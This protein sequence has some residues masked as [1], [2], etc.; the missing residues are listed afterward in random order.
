MKKFIYIFLTLCAAVSCITPFDLDYDET[1]VI[2][3]EAY[4]GADSEY[5]RL[6][7]EPAYSKSNSVTVIPFNPVIVFEVD[8][9]PVQV[10]CV[11]A[12]DGY[13][14][15]HHKP[16]PGEKMKVSVTS[17]G[18]VGISAET[19]IPDAF[20]ARKIDYR[21]VETGIDKYASVLYI[22]PECI[23]PKWC[24]GV[25]FLNEYTYEDI[26]GP[27]TRTYKYSGRLF[28]DPDSGFDELVP[29][30]MTAMNLDLLGA[31]LW[32][33][34]GDQLDR[35][36]CTFALQ[37]VSTWTSEYDAHE[38]FYASSGERMQYDEEGNVIGVGKYTDRNKVLLYT[39]TDEFYKYR[40]AYELQMDYDGIVG[41]IAPANFC[42]SNINNGYGAFAGIYIVETDWITKDFIENN[43]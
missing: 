11:D 40:V 26:S 5:I 6:T 42:Y 28:P 10:E 18:F 31:T 19:V 22:T 16:M 38:S 1:P 29:M 37:P 39:M 21:L 2:F 8:G 41:V 36:S 4:P 35:N 33:W 7:I 17:E 9:N 14:I 30:S 3:L 43:R 23:D 27:N 12:E 15:A 25:Q 20:P 13:Y 24:Y 32:T 34:D